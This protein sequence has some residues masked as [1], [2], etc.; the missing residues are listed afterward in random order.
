MEKS[1]ENNK[2]KIY[3]DILRIIACFLVLLCHTISFT[4]NSKVIEENWFIS[5]ALYYIS[6]IAV[7][8]FFM[9]SGA[10]MLRKDIDYRQIAKKIFFRLLIPL[11]VISIIIYFKRTPIFNLENIINFVKEFLNAEILLPLWFL[12]SLIGMYICTPFLRKMVKNMEDKDF[13]ILFAI[14]IIATG[15]IPIISYYT[16]IKITNYFI[17]PI[18]GRYIPYYLL[19][20]Y[21]FERNAIKTTKKGLILVSILGLVSLIFSVVLTYFDIKIFQ[22]E[23]MF[24]DKVDYINL[25]IMT[26]SVCYIVKYIFENRKFSE[27]VEKLIVNIS[28]TTFGIYI[29]HGV[30]IGHFQFIYN[31]IS[32]YVGTSIGIILHNLVFFAI[33]SCIIYVIIKIPF[34]NKFI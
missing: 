14:W 9:V 27:K 30:L 15:I 2:R 34:V 33:L 24:L 13:K 29:I 4:Y 6:K 25:I 1:I 22:K 26:F 17:I 16:Q 7:P 28:S 32:R 3:L 31:N 21:M 19:G 10:L 8:I 11:L 23:T 5:N 18:I 12:Y 20:Y